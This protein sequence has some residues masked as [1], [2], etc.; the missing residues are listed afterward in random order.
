MALPTRP[1]APGPLSCASRAASARTATPAPSSSWCHPVGVTTSLLLI[2]ALCVI[3]TF[4]RRHP[5]PAHHGGQLLRFGCT[6]PPSQ[7]ALGM[8]TAPPVHRDALAC[9][10][11][12]C[13]PPLMNLQL[14]WSA[15]PRLVWMRRHA[16][17]TSPL[18]RCLPSSQLHVPAPASCKC[19]IC[20]QM[21]P[22]SAL[23][24]LP[25]VHGACPQPHR[26][27]SHALH[28]FGL[29]RSPIYTLFRLHS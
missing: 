26:S 11:R 4:A 25:S 3:R 18:C 1:T 28:L 13:R 10:D 17:R 16:R 8:L 12:P 2:M 7:P 20:L 6:P 5:P 24:P 27:R 23:S 14:A 19:Q 29:I 22:F 15:M 21:P 9:A